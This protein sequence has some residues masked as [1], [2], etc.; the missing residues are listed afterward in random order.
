[1]HERRGNMKFY[2][3]VKFLI[4]IA[5][6]LIIAIVAVLI[7]KFSGNANHEVGGSSPKPNVTNSTAPVNTTGFVNP[8][9][10]QAPKVTDSAAK[11]TDEPS[12]IPSIANP[13]IPLVVTEGTMDDVYAR[14]NELKALKAQNPNAVIILLDVG[15]GGFDPGSGGIDSGVTESELNLAVAKFVAEK[16]GEKGYYVFMTRMGEYAVANTKAEDMAARTAMMKNDI[17]TVA[18]SIHMNSFPSD[19]SVNG[20]RLFCYPGS[21]QGQSLAA[22]IMSKIAAAT[23]QRNRDV[24]ADDLMVVREPI[25]PSALVEC[26]FLSNSSDEANLRTTSYQQ[27]LAQAVADGVQS[28]IEGL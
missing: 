6:A 1:M 17:F 18:I 7:G 21:I 4:L 9:F 16:L 15:H 20:T 5:A 26:G 28:Y 25:C 10:S 13:S 23:G 24:V 22:G 19:R 3:T 14:L 27:T 8:N 12:S 11:P 2:K